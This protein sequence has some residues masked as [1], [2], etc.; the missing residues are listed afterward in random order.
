MATSIR[1]D[2]ACVRLFQRIAAT[3]AQGTGLAKA[4]LVGEQLGLSWEQTDTLCADLQVAGLVQPTPAHLFVSVNTLRT[5]TRH[6]FTKLDVTTRRA[7]VQRA[8]DL[9]LAQA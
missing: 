1:T 4:H 3:A 2:E 6:I 8:A 9:G 5:H 7:A